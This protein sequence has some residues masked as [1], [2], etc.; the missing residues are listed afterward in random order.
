MV[1]RLGFE[2]RTNDLKGRCSTVELSTPMNCSFSSKQRR[3]N[4]EQVESHPLHSFA[5][6]KRELQERDTTKFW[7][8]PGIRGLLRNSANLVYYRLTKSR[9]KKKFPRVFQSKG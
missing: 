9:G 3:D 2:P 5:H 7:K 8:E 6:A 4:I 1:G